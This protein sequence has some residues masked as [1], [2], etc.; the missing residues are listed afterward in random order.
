MIS[1]MQAIVTNRRTE[2]YGDS[3]PRLKQDTVTKL[4]HPEFQQGDNIKIT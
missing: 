2:I 1:S 3:V 4:A